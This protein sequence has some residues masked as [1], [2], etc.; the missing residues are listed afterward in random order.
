MDLH[1]DEI[2]SLEYHACSS[3]TSTQPIV[4]D[5]ILRAIIELRRRRAE[6]AAVEREIMRQRDEHRAALNRIADRLHVVHEDPKIEAKVAA[7]SLDREVKEVALQNLA[8]VVESYLVGSSDREMLRYVLGVTQ[9]ILLTSG[10]D[11]AHASAVPERLDNGF[12]QGSAE[13]RATWWTC[14]G[15]GFHG[16]FVGTRAVDGQKRCL[17]SCGGTTRN[18]HVGLGLSRG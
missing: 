13:D 8:N 4:R 15:C 17:G 14:E 1:D 2:E 11:P 6:P 9:Q 12:L 3:G 10:R 5:A 18:P 16:P 7:V